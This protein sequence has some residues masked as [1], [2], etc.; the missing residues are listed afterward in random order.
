M[1]QQTIV[2]LSHDADEAESDGNLYDHL[3]EF[4]PPYAQRDIA[5]PQSQL[6]ALTD[7]DRMSVGRIVVATIIDHLR[8]LGHYASDSTHAGEI[9][10]IAK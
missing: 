3:S 7:P 2:D 8:Y 10:G 9:F 1:T 4:P 5:V 6:A